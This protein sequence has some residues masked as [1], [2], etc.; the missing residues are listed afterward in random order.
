[1]IQFIVGA[2]A[3]LA[4]VAAVFFLR[5]WRQTEDRL[6]ARFALAFGLLSFQWVILAATSPAHE[7]RPLIF[8]IRLVAFSLILAA[9][10]E[11]NRLKDP[12]GSPPAPGAGRGP[13]VTSR[14]GT[15]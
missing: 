1:M 4:A 2:N 14:P 15:A 11:K 13:A 5:F 12:A 10:I 6:F 8:A 3:A 9:V 7:F